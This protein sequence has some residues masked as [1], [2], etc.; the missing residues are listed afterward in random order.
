MEKAME[1]AGASRRTILK[2]GA[3]VAGASLLSSISGSQFA[4]AAVTP[5]ALSDFSALKGKKIGM[6]VVDISTPVSTRAAAQ[7]KVL[8]KKYGFSLEV[9][10][11]AGDFNKVNSTLATWATKKLDG[12]IDVGVDPTPIKNG[13][14]KLTDANIPIGGIYAGYSSGAGLMWDVTT[15]E[16]INYA[17]V[18]TYLLDRLGATG[19]GSVAIIN[20]PQV[21]VLRIRSAVVNQMLDFYNIEILADEVLAVPGQV[22]DAK[23]KVGALL[24]KYPAGGKLKAIVAGWDE[25]GQ[26]ASQAIKEAGRTDVFVVSS[27]GNLEALEMIRNGDP[28]AATC[29]NDIQGMTTTCFGQLS[30]VIGGA[31][32]MATSLY[33]DAPLVTKENLPA[34]GKYAI[35]NGLTPFY[36]K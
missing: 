34:K 7:G 14:S 33:V 32:P 29:G 20:W 36:V 13:I 11:A 22:V 24:T 17:K 10:N 3:L 27:D 18:G 35:G 28:F 12:V 30:A 9:F 4:E 21:P 31:K 25:V 1:E 23:Q 8:A 6:F 19:G 15:N 16:W 26:A 2:G 5:K